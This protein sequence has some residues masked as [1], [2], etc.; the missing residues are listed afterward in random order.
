MI[1]S[2]VSPAHASPVGQTVFGNQQSSFLIS[3]NSYMNIKPTGGVTCA[4]VFFIAFGVLP[5]IF[6]ILWRQ[7]EANR[8]NSWSYSNN[9]EIW[10]G[11]TY[12]L[13]VICAMCCTSVGTYLSQTTK[14]DSLNEYIAELRS[15]KV[16][17]ATRHLVCAGFGLFFT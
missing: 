16:G 10:M 5:V 6:L 11:V 15:Q 17:N 13:Y 7:E 9:Y 14:S 8:K 2:I 12:G 3:S 1:S 4:S